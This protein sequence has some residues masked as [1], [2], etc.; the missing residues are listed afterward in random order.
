MP[1]PSL[2]VLKVTL[3]QSHE[4]LIAVSDYIQKRLRPLKPR[5]PPTR[6]FPIYW[7]YIR[8]HNWISSLAKLNSV[9]DVQ[10]I[11]CGLRAL[12][13]LA[14][15]MVMLHCHPTDESAL[16]VDAW[17]QS[18]KLKYLMLTEDFE[19]R[20]LGA[21]VDTSA[22]IANNKLGI[23]ESRNRFWPRKRQTNKHPERWTGRVN[24]LEDVR[25]A[26]LLLGDEIRSY[27]G[28]NLEQFYEFDYRRLNRFV[29][30]SGYVG[31]SYQH[32][33]LYLM[34]STGHSS[35]IRLALLCSYIYLKEIDFGPDERPPSPTHD[36]ANI[37]EF[38][39]PGS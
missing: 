30:G 9:A 32:E 36:L 18:A 3:R 14:T 21:V 22:F 2:E 26:D 25:A 13:E 5:N 35:C 19:R 12:L 37:L 7:S 24:L 28:V 4:Q 34:G 1:E 23:E 11:C 38:L 20:K 17:V 8:V 10:A 15:D 31:Y 6:R 33:V 39:K 27:L 29:H 16:K